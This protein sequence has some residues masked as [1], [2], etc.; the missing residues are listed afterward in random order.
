VTIA[1][2]LLCKDGAVLAADSQETVQGYWKR[3]QVKI[4]GTTLGHAQDLSLAM[5]GAGR[6]GYIDALIEHLI[7][8]AVPADGKWHATLETIRLGLIAFH[9][10]HVAPYQHDPPEANLVI[11][12][13]KG[14]HLPALFSTDRSTITPM[15]ANVGAVAVGIGAG[16]ALAILNRAAAQALSMDSAIAL[17]AYV[18]HHTK[19]HVADCG[20]ITNLVGIRRGETLAVP[21][22]A[23][24]AMDAE[25][26][27]FMEATEPHIVQM[28][29][30]AREVT[31]SGLA[32]RLLSARKAIMKAAKVRVVRSGVETVIG[33]HPS[34]DE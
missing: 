2:G 16:H 18:I 11:A 5:A 23:I 24:A 20:D 7:G 22:E 29:V 12:M 15:F 8:S 31:G 14:K 33:T 17:A 26:S 34:K 3:R 4:S 10:D 32:K 1:I 6:A 21:D 30:G 25:F 13:Q 9:R 27:R 19:H 28:L